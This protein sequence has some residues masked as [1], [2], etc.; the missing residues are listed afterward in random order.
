MHDHI[1]SSAF[2]AGGGEMGAL[3]RSYDFG[4]LVSRAALSVAAE[5]ACQSS[6]E[7]DGNSSASDR[8]QQIIRQLGGTLALADGPF[9][10]YA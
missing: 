1:S 3:M 10:L 8:A 2:L 5:P 4:L 7:L 9:S 6:L